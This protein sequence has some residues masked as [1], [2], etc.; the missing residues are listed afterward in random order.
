MR[1]SGL[2]M[3]GGEH[4]TLILAAFLV[5]QEPAIKEFFIRY[6]SAFYDSLV[7]NMLAGGKP[8]LTFG[9]HSV[10]SFFF[11]LFSY[12]NARTYATRGG[13]FALL[14]AVL[15]LVACG[16]SI[17]M[18]ACFLIPIGVGA[19]IA[20]TWGRRIALVVGMFAVLASI[21]LVVLSVEDWA[22]VRYAVNEIVN[23][24]EGGASGIS[25]RYSSSGVLVPTIE[26]IK[27][28]P[29]TPVGIGFSE[30]LLEC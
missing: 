25:V 20:H 16:F 26:Y 5:L 4:K 12:L 22:K 14:M 19:L 8:V 27:A 30:V 3:A 18:T 2:D 17:C 28:H 7:P 10:A 13:W 6:Y 23:A 29:L 15:Y 9:S 11:F 21:A 1:A 24:E